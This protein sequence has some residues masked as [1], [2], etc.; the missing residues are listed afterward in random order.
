MVFTANMITWVATL[1]RQGIDFKDLV[2]EDQFMI[3]FLDLT[4]EE[5]AEYLFG[6]EFDPDYIN[7][8]QLEGKIKN[9]STDNLTASIDWRK[10]GKVTPVK[11]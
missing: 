10:R 5:K 6:F 8:M 11:D 2:E 7:H 3:P 9:L 4:C 1:E